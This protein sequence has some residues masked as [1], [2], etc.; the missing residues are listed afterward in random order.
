ML[1]M[2]SV[3][4][5]ALVDGLVVMVELKKEL[6]QSAVAQNISVVMSLSYEGES[7][8]GPPQSFKAG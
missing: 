5:R 4:C 2:C 7:A 1:T 6:K 8:D 3:T